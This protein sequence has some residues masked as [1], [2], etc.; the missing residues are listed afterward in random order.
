VAVFIIAGFGIQGETPFHNDPLDEVR[1]FWEEDGETYLLGDYLL[2]LASFLGLL[3]FFVGIGSLLRRAEGEPA[4]WSRVGF[5]SGLLMIAVAAIASGPWTALAF[6]AEVLSDDAIET[7]M[8]LDLGMWHAF[9]FAGGTFILA[10]SL[11]IA[12]T[13][14]LWRWLGFAGIVIGVLALILPAG[15]IGASPADDPEEGIFGIVGL[16]TFFGLMIWFLLA[17]IGMVMLKEEPL[18]A[19]QRTM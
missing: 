13:G 10:S 15:I 7:L 11:I 5:Y 14:A 8:Y 19:V 18:P 17:S 4:L 16:I 6:G 12:Q 1:A 3:P 2:G 9:I